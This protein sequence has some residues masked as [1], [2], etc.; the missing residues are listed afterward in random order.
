MRLRF[1]YTTFEGATVSTS[2]FEMA[3]HFCIKLLLEFCKKLIDQ[4]MEGVGMTANG[5]E[6][7]F[8]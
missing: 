4:G 8:W 2:F 1:I 3:N 6:V 5:C 7:S